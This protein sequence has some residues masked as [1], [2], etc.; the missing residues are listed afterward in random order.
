MKATWLGTIGVVVLVVIVVL[1]SRLD[2]GAQAPARPTIENAFSSDELSVCNS[3]APAESATE[4]GTVLTPLIYAT[5]FE[6]VQGFTA[7]DS[8]LA[9]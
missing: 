7:R 4:P 3:R 1:G 6:P 8:H 5:G 2:A 9:S